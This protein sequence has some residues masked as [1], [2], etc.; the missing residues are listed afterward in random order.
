MGKNSVVFHLGTCCPPGDIW[1]CLEIFL[2]V[3]TGAG[4]SS[5]GIYGAEAW[6]A[7][8][9]STMHRTTPQKKNYL[10]EKSI[11]LGLKNPEWQSVTD[12]FA[13]MLYHLSTT[14]TVKVPANC[15][16]V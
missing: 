9:Y 12:K 3:T 10:A 6:G 7:T 2:V 4:D 14:T 5:T 1:Q 16:Q 13:S 15:S 8:K 11:M